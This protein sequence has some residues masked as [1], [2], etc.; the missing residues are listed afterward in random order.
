MSK[1]TTPIE[2]KTEME[3]FYG[4][5]IISMEKEKR[6]SVKI[7]KASIIDDLFL[8]WKLE[9]ELPSHSRKSSTESC[10]VPI[11]DH[12]KFAIQKLHKHLALICDQVKQPKKTEIDEIEYEGF[13]VS[14]F[15]IKGRDENHGVTIIGTREGKYGTVNLKSPVA[16]Y[17]SSAYPFISELGLDV[18]D[19]IAEVEAYLFDGKRAPDRQLDIDFPEAPEDNG[20]GQE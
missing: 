2:V 12:L 10:T 19:A 20:E 7:L 9:E 8:E 1:K 18:N 14:G 6:A 5:A 4:P 11:H 16:K 13:T 17:D 3:V 15:E